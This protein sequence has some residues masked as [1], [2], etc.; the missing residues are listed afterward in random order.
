MN[1][2]KRFKTMLNGK[3]YTLIGSSS[4]EHMESVSKLLNDELTKL[5]KQVNNISTEDAAI[6]LAFNAISDQLDKELELEKL[7]NKV[8]TDN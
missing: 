2:K 3:T 7:K 1:N 5:K 6:L 4:D 8:E